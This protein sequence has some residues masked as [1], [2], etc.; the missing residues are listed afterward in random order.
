MLPSSTYSILIQA[1]NKI[2]T[3]C[4]HLPVKFSTK[5]LSDDCGTLYYWGKV[6]PVGITGAIESSCTISPTCFSEGG[7][8][9][10]YAT[11]SYYNMYLV[12]SNN[13]LCEFVLK[14]E[15][16]TPC[17]PNIKYVKQISC[18]NTFILAL[19]QL[20][21][22]YGWGESKCGALGQGVDDQTLKEPTSIN[23]KEELGLEIAT[24]DNICVAL[25]KGESSN[26]VYIWGS[27]PEIELK[28]T[29]REGY[30]LK[31]LLRPTKVPDEDTK[32]NVEH[33]YTCSSAIFLRC[34]NN[35]V[36]PIGIGLNGC[37]G[38]GPGI[39]T[40][41]LLL[42]SI[43]IAFPCKAPYKII[44]FSCGF[45]HCLALLEDAESK[46]HIYGWGNNEYHKC[47]P[48]PMKGKKFYSPTEFV[49]TLD[50]VDV[51]CGTFH[52][53]LMNKAGE[54]Y[55]YGYSASGVLGVTSNMDGIIGTPTQVCKNI[56]GKSVVKMMACKTNSYAII[57]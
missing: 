18:G 13:T 23:F 35:D 40:D 51:Q 10:T 41:S 15:T 16:I 4:K 54:I 55:A 19:T 8:T 6:T 42:P 47:I 57:N 32:G 20:G 25:T 22:I 21:Q 50:L 30:C 7:N 46:K 37:L 29:I 45:D 56:K 28:T 24:S 17:I 52:T 44:S 39:K 12:L 2:G 49:S 26:K 36:L 34:K 14:G 48:L 31:N 5:P 27:C 9:V 53:M 33:I 38:I 11:N 1:V 3:G 43:K